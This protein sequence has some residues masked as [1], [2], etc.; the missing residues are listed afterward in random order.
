MFETTRNQPEPSIIVIF[1]ASGDLTLRKL[2]P[3]LYN[4]ARERLLPENTVITGYGRTDLT[5]QQFREQLK[6]GIRRFSRTQPLEEKVWA[7]L[8]RRL[9]YQQGV[10]DDEDDHRRLHGRLKKL[11]DR[12][13]T[14]GNRIFYMAIPPE[15]V[16]PVLHNLS[17]VG[18]LRRQTP[19]PENQACHLRVV[20]EK[21]FGRDLESARA[22]NDTINSMLDESQ[23]FRMD[24]YL[25]KET[26][27]NISVLRFANSIFEHIWHNQVVRWVR[28]TVAEDIGTE[29][30][31]G[32][33]DSTGILRD[34]L[35][36]HV[37]QLLTLIAMEPPSSLAADAIRDEKAKVLRSLRRLEGDEVSRSV[38]RGQYGEGTVGGEA[39]PAYRA[40]KG[41]APE[42][43]TETFVGLRTYIDNWRWVGVPFYLCAGK[44]LPAKLTEVAVQ[45]KTVPAVLFGAMKE[46]NL[47]PNRLTMRIQP[48]E[49]VSLRFVSKVPGLALDL[50]TV[51]MDFPYGSEFPA[52]S[53]EAYERLLLDV[54]A[55]HAALFARR[56]EVELAWEFATSILNEWER[57]P[58]PDFPN[59]RPGTWGPIST[60]DFFNETTDYSRVGNPNRP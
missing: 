51:E 15:V 31:G 9:F 24:H 47:R 39:V 37:L 5:D 17:G 25:G 29:G 42:S 8:G 54:M 21:P 26:V 6:E 58:P 33:F 41:V 18:A 35:Q 13:D 46:V 56:D 12:F 30:R 50:K 1:G 57:Q 14:G 59:Y 49:G 23:I 40:E 45:F 38:I 53:P 10:Y 27:Q 43:T 44:R 48:D 19:C 60:E 16:E 52:E 7:D 36:N 20:F 2:A 11:D 3:A 4:L 32:Y 22:L 34:I 55:G 28:V